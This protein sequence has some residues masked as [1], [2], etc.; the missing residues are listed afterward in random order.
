MLYACLIEPQHLSKAIS[1]CINVN[2][3]MSLNL[4]MSFK[5]V[6]FAIFIWKPSYKSCWK[7]KICKNIPAY[8][9]F[10]RIENISFF[11][12]MKICYS[13]CKNI[14]E[15]LG[16]KL[17]LSR[18]S[19][20]E[21]PSPVISPLMIMKRRPFGQN[22][23]WAIKCGLIQGYIEII[24]MAPW[25]NLEWSILEYFCNATNIWICVYYND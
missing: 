17:K 7:S 9:D 14:W 10:G 19:V 20:L 12:K 8:I 6:Q 5:R 15:T 2:Q 25:V 1:I 22:C 24:R 3:L 11:E 4:V 13:A 23:T 18:K 16:K 21:P